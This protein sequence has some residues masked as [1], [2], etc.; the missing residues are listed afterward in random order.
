[1][2]RR[3]DAMPFISRSVQIAF[4][5]SHFSSFLAQLQTVCQQFRHL[6]LQVKPKQ[7]PL[8]SSIRTILPVANN[9]N[10]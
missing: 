4:A 6:H 1:M 7:L 2:I 10:N 8:P 3:C 5:N 9:Y